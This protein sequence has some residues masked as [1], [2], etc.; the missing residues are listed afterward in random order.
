MRCIAL[1][2]TRGLTPGSPVVDTGHPLWVPVGDGLLGRV[3]NVSGEV[4]DQKE[5]ITGGEWRS[6]HGQ[7]V[8]LR[9]QSTVSE[10]FETGRTEGRAWALLLDQV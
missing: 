4:I 2:P 5:K 1:T 7:P 8:P 6:I 10:V 3:F 9:R